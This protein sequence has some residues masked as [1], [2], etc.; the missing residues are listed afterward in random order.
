MQ[1]VMELQ[2][3]HGI[4]LCVRLEDGDRVLNQLRNIGFW[5]RRTRQQMCLSDLQN[6]SVV[7]AVNYHSVSFI[8]MYIIW[9]CNVRVFFL[10]V[11]CHCVC[12]QGPPHSIVQGSLVRHEYP[13]AFT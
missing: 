9:P 6:L 3:A 5:H 2:E 8:H 4:K 13:E 12:T 10:E 1:P 7:H 11:M